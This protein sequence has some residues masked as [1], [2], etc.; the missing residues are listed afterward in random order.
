MPLI[1]SDITIGDYQ[2]PLFSGNTVIV[3]SGAAGLNAALQLHRRGVRDIAIVT[4]CWGAGASNNAGSDKQTYYKLAIAGDQKDSPQQMA[5][6][7]CH[8]GSTHG[9]I[10]LCEAQHSLQAF[11][12]LVDLGVSFPHDAYGGYPGYRTDHDPRGRATSA[13][14]RT[15]HEMF[16]CLGAAAKEAG[17]QIFDK[18]QVV[19]L[20]TQTVHDESSVCGLIAI[21]TGALQETNGFVLF[22]TANVI[23]ATGGPGGLFKASV[24]P[25]NQPGS[26]GLGLAC[27][28]MAQNLTEFQYGLSS[29]GFR[30]NL[31]GSYQQAMPRYLST[32]SDGADEREFLLEHFPDSQTLAGA[33]FRKGYE[34]PFDGNKIENYGSSLIDLLVHRE[35]SQRNRRV[36]L[37]YTK[38][39]SNQPFN[40]HQLDGESLHYL[41]R[42]KAL[43][44]T[45]L[46]RLQAMN[47]AAAKLFASHGIDL[48]HDRLEI[49]VCAQHCNGGLTGNI[50]WESNIRHLFPIGEVNG[51]HG[52]RR[53]G[54]A[55]LNAGQVGGIRAAL[56]IAKHYTGPPSTDAHFLQKTRAQITR[57]IDLGNRMSGGGRAESLR[58]DQVIEDLRIR[59]S[60]SAGPIRDP[61][62]VAQS[63]REAWDL[64]QRMGKDLAVSGPHEI[65][66]GFRARDLALTHA[67]VLEAIHE[68]ISKGGLSRGGFLIPQQ[69]GAIECE[70]LGSGACF[71]LN[72]SSAPVEKK[73]LEISVDSKN[74]PQTRWVDIRPVPNPDDW[75]ES[76]WDDYRKG[77]VIP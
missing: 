46:V 49:A 37:D 73:I 42:S 36:Y 18:H 10:A 71:S 69:N 51:S 33:V 43:R 62:G 35:T 66:L 58:P 9:D 12:N 75:F 44:E 52:T 30:W 4:E 34:W 7:L 77:R 72:S 74:R 11:Y 68:Y 31:S 25:E 26:L 20:L 50:W 29:I 13:G 54:G 32:D 59:M 45:P 47:P 61:A 65:G 14:P 22:K 53:P 67:V 64:F 40:P 41:T 23:L 17:I 76:V 70:I 15:S 48:S 38:N 56:Y 3:G 2:I 21:S 8:G 19:A 6:D 27:G 16:A 55:A 24:Y 57:I 1:R 60:R 39:I 5:H 63:R 28:A